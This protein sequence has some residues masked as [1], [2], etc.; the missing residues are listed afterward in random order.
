MFVNFFVLGDTSNE[1]IETVEAHEK[2][3]AHAKKEEEFQLYKEI[4]LVEI[5]PCLMKEEELRKK[6]ENISSSVIIGL[7]LDRLETPLSIVKKRV[8]AIEASL[9]WEN[10][11]LL[12]SAVNELEA[13][14]QEIFILLDEGI[15]RIQTSLI[16]YEI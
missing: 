4:Y 5:H 16:Y 10:T 3:W 7:D 15:F 8:Q 14:L 9:D 11:I 12:Q 1:E 13:R 2:T 6:A